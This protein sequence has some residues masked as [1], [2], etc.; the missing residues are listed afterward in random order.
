MARFSVQSVKKK[1]LAAFAIV[2]LLAGFTCVVLL[3]MHTVI[4]GQVYRSAQLPPVVLRQWVH[5]HGIRSEL[6]LR[7]RNPQRAW[8]LSEIKAARDLGLVHYDIPLWKYYLPKPDQMRELVRIINDSPKP[9]LLHC[10]SGADRS[11]LVSAMVL[12]LRGD[13]VAQAKRQI[14]WLYLAA[15]EGTVGPK[16]LAQYAAWLQSKHEKSSSK[17]FTEWVDSVYPA[18]FGAVKG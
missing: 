13:S 14:S 1:Y 8:Y 2:C 16:V 12:L 18:S 3:N 6:N 4:P 10:A 7:G 11:G 9:L 17:R 15:T 5:F